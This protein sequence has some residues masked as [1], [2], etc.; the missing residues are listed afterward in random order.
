MEVIKIDETIKEIRKSDI[1]LKNHFKLSIINI[2]KIDKAI[3]PIAILV[4]IP[5][6]KAY[7]IPINIGKNIFLFLLL[8]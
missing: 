6:P 3:N 8:I 4:L 5:I 7:I 2:E 1:N